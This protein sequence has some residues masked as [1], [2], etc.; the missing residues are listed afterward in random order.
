MRAVLEL[1][2]QW[3]KAVDNNHNPV[4]VLSF[5]RAIELDCSSVVEGLP[6]ICV[7]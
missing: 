1:A 2:K 3:S 5:E 6:S 4:I 7:F